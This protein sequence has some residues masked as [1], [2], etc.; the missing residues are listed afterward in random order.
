MTGKIAEHYS[1]SDVDI[2]DLLINSEFV[3]LKINILIV[4]ILVYIA[5][6]GLY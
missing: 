1:S 3:G 2:V 4:S 6:G 5:S